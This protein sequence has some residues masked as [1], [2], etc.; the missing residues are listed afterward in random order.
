M[1]CGF[2]RHR[3]DFQQRLRIPSN[4]C[5]FSD[6]RADSSR[7]DPG[8]FLRFRPDSDGFSPKKHPS[9][10]FSGN[11]RSARPAEN[12]HGTSKIRTASQESARPIE[13]PH[14]P[15]RIRTTALRPTQRT[16]TADPP[17]PDHGKRAC[18]AGH[19]RERHTPAMGPTDANPTGPAR[20]IPGTTRPGNKKGGIPIRGPRQQV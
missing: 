20:T 6:G 2:L 1:P 19:A 12:P 17:R 3:A 4:V 16:H 15:S 9:Y 18:L 10:D 14:D 7:G 13:N 11:R 8:P 5:G